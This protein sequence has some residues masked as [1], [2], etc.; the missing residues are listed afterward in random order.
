MTIA[1]CDGDPSLGTDETGANDV[2]EAVTAA[3]TSTPAITSPPSGTVFKTTSVTFAWPAGADEY[4]LRAGRASGGSEL[5]QS[6]SLGKATTALIPGLPLDGGKVFVTLVSRFGT[7]EKTSTTRYTAAVGRGLCVVADFADKTLE[8]WTGP[9]FRSLS[10][11]STVL[12]LMQRHWQWLSRDTEQ[13]KWDTI[14]V[15]LA[16]PLSPSAFADATAYREEVLRLVTKKVKISDYDVDGDG[17]IDAIWIIGVNDGF[18]LGYMDGGTARASVANIFVDPQNSDS[19]VTGS[20][21]NFN[22][23]LGHCHGLPDLYGPDSTVSELTL[24]G[25]SWPVPPRDFTAYERT[26]LRW[27]KPTLV[28]ATTHGIVLPSAN[29]GFAALMIPTTRASEYFLV[30]Y[31]DTPASGYGSGGPALNGLAVYHVL[32]G[33]SRVAG[34]RRCC[35][36]CPPTA[37]WPPET[38]RT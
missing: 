17:I 11:I 1:A 32:E 13:F 38:R 22:H 33:A 15:K 21:G 28:A 3:V 24:M 7:R 9:G 5:F 36:S 4:W 6:P 16:V 35:G 34:P 25:D 2:T 10:D 12:N 19:I 23:E 14:R 31:R 26:A 8:S 20:Y 30:E 18:S 29:E 37:S 27:L